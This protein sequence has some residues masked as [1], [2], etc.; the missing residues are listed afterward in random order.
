MSEILSK[1]Q[2]FLIAA[3]LVCIL[4]ALFKNEIKITDKFIIPQRQT[5]QQFVFGIL[6]ISLC[7]IGIIL[8]FPHETP[9]PTPPK[10]EKIVTE[11]KDTIPS[12]DE[13][14]TPTTMSLHGKILDIFKKPIESGLVE[15]FIAQEQKDSKYTDAEG[16]FVF[17]HL[18][19]ELTCKIAYKDTEKGISLNKPE[20]T[21]TV[22]YNPLNLAKTEFILCRNTTK[23]KNETR[24]AIE[25]YDDHII[26][27]PI[28][29]LP[30]DETGMHYI[31]CIAKI[32]GDQ[33]Y[34]IDEKDTIMYCWSTS[35][36]SEEFKP[37]KQTISFHEQ[38]YGTW[39]TKKVW[40]GNWKLTVKTVNN[41]VLKTINFSII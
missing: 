40:K 36:C 22:Y 25:K 7:T 38:G 39:A 10:K 41:T 11:V 19:P 34:A 28:E 4:A 8:L 6:G 33:K 3:G 12:K 16:K 32:Y 21:I 37:Y 15:L 29:S 31:S 35:S 9:P 24:T 30:K 2:T 26:Q 5:W 20:N 13:I 23:N 27:I 18:E 17:K 1:P 14:I